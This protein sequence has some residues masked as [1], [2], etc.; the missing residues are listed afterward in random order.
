M[1]TQIM[2]AP[3]NHKGGLKIEIIANQGESQ[4]SLAEIFKERKLASM[5]L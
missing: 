5:K 2:R 1:G 3:E 4:K